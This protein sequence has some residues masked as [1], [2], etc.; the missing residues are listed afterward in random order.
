MPL[1]FTPS[2][3]CDGDTQLKAAEY[4]I[5]AGITLAA[6]F[7]SLSLT[8]QKT[9]TDVTA[10]WGELSFTHTPQPVAVTDAHLLV[11]VE[12]GLLP[13]STILR[14]RLRSAAW[15]RSVADVEFRKAD[16]LTVP[17]EGLNYRRDL[18][19]QGKGK[20][21]EYYF[22]LVDPRDS[23]LM[24]LPASKDSLLS[25][26]FEGETS[27][28]VTGGVRILE[29]LALFLAGISLLQVVNPTAGG[30]DYRRFL[31]LTS[32]WAGARML[33]TLLGA[34]ALG[35][36]FGTAWRGFPIGVHHPQTIEAVASLVALL[37]VV[38]VL[39]TRKR[40]DEEEHL[41]PPVQVRAMTGISFLLTFV[42]AVLPWRLGI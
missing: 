20:R 36:A 42:A 14:L 32:F 29:S 26:R 37:T 11:S 21:F 25:I 41:P 2:S 30:L 28:A 27:V 3:K 35:S 4:I 12:G 19:H 40:V 5:A 38:A 7:F 22:E 33:A 17:G 15:L 34:M 23:V 39:S 24:T 9:A 6:L 1:S 10:Q 16:L 31:L 8:R 13:D 18:S